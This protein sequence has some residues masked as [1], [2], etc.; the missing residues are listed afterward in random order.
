MAGLVSSISEVALIEELQLNSDYSSSNPLFR[1]LGEGGV[2]KSSF[3]QDLIGSHGN[4]THFSH[5][6]CVFHETHFSQLT[7][8]IDI[9]SLT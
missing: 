2:G 5:S 1:F 9:S 8:Q 7:S 3:L 4:R 6:C